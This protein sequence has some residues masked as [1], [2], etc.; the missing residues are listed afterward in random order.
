[1]VLGLQAHVTP[2]IFFSKILRSDALVYNSY[3]F[4][5]VVLRKLFDIRFS[6]KHCN[7]SRVCLLVKVASKTVTRSMI[8]MRKTEK[9]AIVI[10]A[11]TL[12]HRASYRRVQKNLSKSLNLKSPLKGHLSVVCCF[13]RFIPLK[14]T[15]FTQ[16][17]T[18]LKVLLRKMHGYQCFRKQPVSSWRE[19]G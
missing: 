17:S 11:A 13:F 8:K 3:F 2:S 1:M 5:T 4:R 12:S 14:T 9:N 7:F 19:I 15:S 10:E 18:A 16:F 6:N